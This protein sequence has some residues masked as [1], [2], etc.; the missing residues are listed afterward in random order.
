MDKSSESPEHSTMPDQLQDGAKRGRPETSSESSPPQDKSNK[1]PR[2]E[3]PPKAMDKQSVEDR[4]AHRGKTA[5][6][7]TICPKHN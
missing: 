6:I 1:Q 7:Q 5:F 3:S 2:I 4:S